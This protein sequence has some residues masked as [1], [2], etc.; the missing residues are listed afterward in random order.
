MIQKSDR[1][2]LDVKQNYV[3]Q[4]DGASQGSKNSISRR[5]LLLPAL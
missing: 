2:P 3:L 1:V 4:Q 5:S